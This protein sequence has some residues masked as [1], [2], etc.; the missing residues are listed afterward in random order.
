[1]EVEGF[2]SNLT[3]EER[4]LRVQKERGLARSRDLE[5]AGLSRSQIRRLHA[6]GVI[7]RVARG[8]YR[9]PDAPVTERSE[10][11][12]AARRVPGGVLCLLS[13]LLFH[14]LTTQNPFEVWL[15]IDRKAWRP[16][17]V[18]SPIRFV[19]LSGRPLT[20]GVEEHLVDDVPVGVFGTA[21]TVADGFTFRNQIGVRV[22]VEALHAYRESHPREIDALERFAEVDRATRV[23]RPYLEAIA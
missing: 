12:E 23:M 4:A 9:D 17:V 8:V 19:Y 6:R 16:R 22:A 10:I 5:G 18:P 7:Q 3:P 1:M 15:G 14:G 11:A 2:A 20:A 13:A 21:K